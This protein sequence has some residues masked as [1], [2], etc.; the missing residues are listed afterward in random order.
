MGLALPKI[1]NAFV[2]LPEAVAS[3]RQRWGILRW[4]HF[5]T[6]SKKGLSE[7]NRKGKVI[8]DTG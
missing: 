2:R 4:A 5:I 7:P 1:R 3:G 8:N 6:T